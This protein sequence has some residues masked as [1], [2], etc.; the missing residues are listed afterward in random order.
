M[1]GEY[2][3]ATR[4]LLKELERDGLS[5]DDLFYGLDQP[6]K[7]LRLAA[8]WCKRD[9]LVLLAVADE[10]ELE[11]ERCRKALNAAEEALRR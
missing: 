1:C 11:R 5:G 9:S 3:E 8:L 4:A 6:I 10:L 7:T 2:S